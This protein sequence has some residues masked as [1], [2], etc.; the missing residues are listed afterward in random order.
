ML[1]STVAEVRRRAA[2]GRPGAR[3]AR[4]A[5]RRS[6]RTAGPAGRASRAVVSTGLARHAD[7]G[8]V[9]GLDERRRRPLA[10]GVS[11]DAARRRRCPAS[12][13]PVSAAVGSVER[14]AASSAKSAPAS[15]SA[16]TAS[17][18]ASVATRMW[19]THSAPSAGRRLARS[20]A[21]SSAASGAA[22]PAP[23]PSAPAARRRACRWTSSG[24][25]RTGL[26]SS[27]RRPRASARSSSVIASP[28]AARNCL[29]AIVPDEL[30]Q[31]AAAG[32]AGD[33]AGGRVAR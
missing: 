25:S 21:R 26:P 15:S 20:A 22:D 33:R 14:S 16:T 12:T 11:G 18:S 7:L 30:G 32:V 9:G 17:A 29:V 13:P 6:R 10:L 8:A 2:A 19:R 4:R 3:T 23:W 31:R 27:Q 1:T 28:L 5:T 24:T